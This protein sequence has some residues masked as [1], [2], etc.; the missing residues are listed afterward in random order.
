MRPSVVAL[1]LGLLATSALADPLPVGPLRLPGLRRV[2]FLTPPEGPL[3]GSL[4]AAGLDA[5]SLDPVSMVASIR[6]LGS[7]GEA[8]LD[9]LR[10]SRLVAVEVAVLESG[11]PTEEVRTAARRIGLVDWEPLRRRPATAR[12][13][14]NGRR[15]LVL[16]RL[17]LLLRERGGESLATPA[18]L[19]AHELVHVAQE[20]WGS[21]GV[22][23]GPW[24]FRDLRDEA[25]AELLAGMVD[26]AELLRRP[27]G[28]RR[29]RTER[30]LIR[31]FR[32]P[33]QR[34]LR[35]LARDLRGGYPGLPADPSQDPD[36][37]H[38]GRDPFR[39]LPE[40]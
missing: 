10:F 14:S 11:R 32:R 20:T 8:V 6:G 2:V 24:T 29:S 31:R 16:I 3:P 1:L 17:D 18:G 37:Y 23:G 13:I 22:G 36:R 19:L 28:R 7:L 39:D 27:P 34:L 26:R 35:E 5:E 12:W 33:S 40:R 4:R 15:G 30:A 21:L 9:A 38:P 25:E